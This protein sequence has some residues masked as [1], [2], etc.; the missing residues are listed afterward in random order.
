MRCFSKPAIAEE[1]PELSAA[2]KLEAARREIVDADAAVRAADVAL[3]TYLQIHPNA[4]RIQRIGNNNF[5]R[6]N[7]MDADL[8]LTQLERVRD[9]AK[10]RFARALDAHASLKE[11]TE[12]HYVA[13]KRV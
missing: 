11:T 1:P 2:E 5:Y 10:E 4:H 9:E 12:V 13:G 7:A 6:L 3:S 8:A